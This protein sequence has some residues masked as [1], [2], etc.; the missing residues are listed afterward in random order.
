MLRIF[1]GIYIREKRN[2]IAFN[3]IFSERKI[4]ISRLLCKNTGNK[5]KTF[6]RILS[7]QNKET[8][9]ISKPGSASGLLIPFPRYFTCPKFVG[10][11]KRTQASPQLISRSSHSKIFYFILVSPIVFR[12]FTSENR[13]CKK[14]SFNF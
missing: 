6:R 5:F 9:F 13:Q 7:L 11:K 12:A 10:E 4:I 1:F 14:Y 3:D 2:F 8:D